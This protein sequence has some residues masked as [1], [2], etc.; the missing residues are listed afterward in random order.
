MISYYKQA[1]HI[2]IAALPENSI[3]QDRVLELLE[4]PSNV[5]HGDIAFPCFQLAKT[6][7][8][9]PASIAKDTVDKIQLDKS[10]KGVFSKI[11]VAGPYINFTLSLSS[12]ASFLSEVLEEKDRYGHKERKTKEKVLIEY[13]SPNIAKELHIGHLRS[14]ILGESLKRIYRACGREVIALNHL[15][16]WGTQFGKVIY[17]FLKWGN[18]SQ[19]QQSPMKHLTELYIRFHTEAK[20][21]PDINVHVKDVVNSLEAGDAK[22]RK[23]WKEFVELSL[24][25]IKKKYDRLDVSFDEYLG[26]SF[27][28][29]K[30]EDTVN[31]LKKKKLLQKDQG[32]SIVSLD[33]YKMPPFIVFTREGNTLYHLRDLAA[34][35]YRKEHFKFQKMLYVVGSEQSLHFQQVFKVL[36]LMGFSWMKDLKHIKYGLYRFKEGKLSTRQGRTILL[37]DVLEEAHERALKIIEEKNPELPDKEEVAEKI[38]IGAIIFN[39]LFTDPIKDVEF[40]WN[41]ILDFT[42]D[43]GPYIQYSFVRAQSILHKAKKNNTDIDIS[44]IKEWDLKSYESSQTFS[45]KETQALLRAFAQFS[46]ELEQSMRLEKPSILAQYVL[47]LAKSFHVFYREV[48]VLD[49]SLSREERNL[50][51]AL[52]K[53][54]AQLIRNGLDLLC[55]KTPSHM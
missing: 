32:A 50:R 24:K 34:A 6:L 10:Q 2:L 40:D 4:K 31:V 15:G 28:L 23:I 36:S 49:E 25:E 41:K 37:E 44:F 16:D 22:V 9:S 54:S 5:Q 33:A 7:K 42:G 35:I 3:S 27:Y 43:T 8:K 17:A 20:S 11:Q 14:T 1:T 45:A 51:L 52:V 21:N 19:L 30:L 12:L 29:D 46:L 18:D 38:G 39:D 47:C 26:E 13:S 55:L 53:A 48:H